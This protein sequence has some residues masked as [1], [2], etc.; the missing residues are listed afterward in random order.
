MERCCRGFTV[1]LRRHLG[2]NTSCKPWVAATVS[3]AA[4]EPGSREGKDAGPAGFSPSSSSSDRNAVATVLAS[5]AL[6]PAEL[7]RQ[8]PI[9]YSQLTPALAQV[10]AEVHVARVARAKASIRM[11]AAELMARTCF[12]AGRLA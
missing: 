6:N 4:G 9:A 3:A 7:E 2:G 12:L 1:G 10:L 8:Q 5:A 11:H